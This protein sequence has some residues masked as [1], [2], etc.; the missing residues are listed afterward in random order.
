MLWKAAEGKVWNLAFLPDGRSIVSAS[1]DCAMSLWDLSNCACKRRWEFDYV[2]RQVA[3]S[4]D[5]AVLGYACFDGS[6]DVLDLRTG[7]RRTLIEAY[8][9][10]NCS[11]TFSPDGG[12]F[13]VGD[14]D[15]TIWIWSTSNYET[16]GSFSTGQSG[17]QV[18][19]LG[20]SSDGKHLGACFLDKDFVSHRVLTWDMHSREKLGE[21]EIERTGSLDLVGSPLRLLL[22]VSPD[23]RSEEARKASPGRVEI[24]DFQMGH[25][26]RELEGAY[27]PAKSDR[28]GRFLACCGRD[29]GLQFWRTEDWS[30]IAALEVASGFPASVDVSPR[31]DRVACGTSE[32]FIHVYQMVV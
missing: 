12:L 25:I 14:C 4:S 19:S 6:Y 15:G 23:T 21:F 1:E 2:V 29:G 16:K 13:V 11:V 7:E 9:G 24:R 32:G 10:S 5:G 8:L 31:R 27:G 30:K 28:S 3:V 22:G 18:M 17:K 26:L 20:F